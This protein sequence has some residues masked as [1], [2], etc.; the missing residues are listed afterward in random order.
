M[1]KLYDTERPVRRLSDIT[2]QAIN[3]VYLEEA[4][5]FTHCLSKVCLQASDVELLE[6]LDRLA[7]HHAGELVN[8]LCNETRHIPDGFRIKDLDEKGFSVY[9]REKIITKFT[10]KRGP[11]MVTAEKLPS[12][13]DI[14]ESCTDRPF[15]SLLRKHFFTRDYA[16]RQLH[17][18]ITAHR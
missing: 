1:E 3:L 9:R 11:H 4:S 7:T 17:R 16:V 18:Q 14:G 2:I 5:F 12:L 13:E 6:V 8:I 15:V 10:L